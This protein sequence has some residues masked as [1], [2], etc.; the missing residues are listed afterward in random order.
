MLSGEKTS[1][2]W[3]LSCKMVVPISCDNCST[4]FARKSDIRASN[5]GSI[6]RPRS[7]DFLS[8][9]L[10]LTDN[11]KQKNANA[12]LNISMLL[13][14]FATETWMKRIIA[15]NIND[16][17]FGW[18]SE[19]ICTYLHGFSHVTY[20]FVDFLR[21]NDQWLYLVISNK[22]RKQSGFRSADLRT[23]Y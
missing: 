17:R 8:T 5:L 19:Y 11:I 18:C 9:S 10:A 3:S 15:L 4:F 23:E 12:N 6:S 22:M 13:L 16:F 7:A 1:V 20:A 21:E 14:L 2:A